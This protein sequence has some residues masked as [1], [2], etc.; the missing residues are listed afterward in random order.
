MKST[1]LPVRAYQGLICTGTFLQSILL[2]AM[3]VTW[4]WA[5]FEAGWGKLTHLDGAAGFFAKLHIPMPYFNAV[6]ASSTETFGGLLLLIG[7]GSRLVSVP[8]MITMIVAYLTAH[9][10]DLSSLDT[11]AKAN[12]FP[13]LLT[14]LVVLCFG[15]GKLSVDYLIQRF[16]LKN[17]NC[18]GSPRAV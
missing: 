14:A 7:L 5:F 6:L 8:L 18:D 10:G 16:V 13:F 2:L 9:R 4:G 17:C 12:P 11:F 1:S 15:P 3:R